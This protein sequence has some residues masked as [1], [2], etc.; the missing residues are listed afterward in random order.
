MGRPPKS[1]NHPLVRLRHK[2]SEW[3]ARE[4]TRKDLAKKAG[5][6]EPSLRDIETGRYKLTPAVATKISFATGVDPRSLLD[7]DDPLLDLLRQPF[8]KD[9]IRWSEYPSW[10]QEYREA[11]EQLFLALLDTAHEKKIGRLI[12]F[13][14]ENWLTTTIEAFGLNDLFAQ[15]L[16]DRFPSFDPKFV[17][18]DFLPKSKRLREEWSDLE[19]ELHMEYGR[20]LLQYDADH[21]AASDPADL[22]DKLVRKVRLQAR[23]HVT[24]KR[25][26]SASKTATAKPLSGKQSRSSQKP[27]A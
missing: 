13:S 12:Y 26:E 1:A 8:S 4:V 24:R 19:Y 25:R 2:L 22:E 18:H 16:I 21:P 9:S 10:P 11:R 15:K 23:E 17:P 14:F 20:L 7:G 6:P 27:A 3:S 5:I